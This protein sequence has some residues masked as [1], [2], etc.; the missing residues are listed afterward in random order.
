MSTDFKAEHFVGILQAQ[1][2]PVVIGPYSLYPLLNAI[3]KVKVEHHYA[4]QIHVTHGSRAAYIL[5]PKVM[6]YWHTHNTVPPYPWV[7][8][9]KT[10]CSYMK[11]WMIPDA[12]YVIF[13]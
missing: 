6:S 5:T 10:Y 11:P 9:S 13:M 1:C 12:M 2:S 8:R 4:L 7:I 3:F